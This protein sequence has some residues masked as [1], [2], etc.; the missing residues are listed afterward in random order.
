MVLHHCI[1]W[2]LS[3]GSIPWPL[4]LGNRR[5]SLTPFIMQ[6]ALSA[7]FNPQLGTAV[8]SLV[9]WWSVRFRT[10]AGGS[11]L[12]R[13]VPLTLPTTGISPSLGLELKSEL[14]HPTYF[15]YVWYVFLK[16]FFYAFDLALRCLAMASFI[17]GVGPC[18]LPS[19]R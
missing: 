15:M 8:R 17:V 7:G 10:M 14:G 6:R 12:R 4:G 9:G 13:T 11:P 1:N 3:R 16:S 19:A 18:V 5:L 2:L